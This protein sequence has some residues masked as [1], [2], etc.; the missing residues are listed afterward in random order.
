VLFCVERNNLQLMGA[1]QEV[2]ERVT[3]NCKLEEVPLN[4]LI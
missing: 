1:R 3:D 2:L 4:V